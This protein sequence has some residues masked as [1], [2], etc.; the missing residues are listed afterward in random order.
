MT[1]A[2]AALHGCRVFVTGHTGFK[3]SWLTLWLSRLGATVTG[4]SL[5]AEPE[6]LFRLAGV[7]DAL[8]AH[9]EADIRDLAALSQALSAARPEIVFHLAAQPLVRASYADPLYTW[10]TNV[11]GTANLLE[12]V[13]AC[14]DVKA[15]VVVTTDKCYESRDTGPAYREGD[16]LGGHDPYSSS[17]A[18]A[19]LVAQSWRR[20][21]FQHGQSPLLATAR[22]GN[23]IGGGDFSV[24]RL[25]PDAARAVA[26]GRALEVRNPG[27][28]RPWQHVLESLRGYL[29]I[30]QGLA[31]GRTEFATAFNLGPSP[32]DNM[33]V[34]DVLQKLTVHWPELRWRTDAAAGKVLHEAPHLQLDSSKA[35]QMLD[36][37][38]AWNLDNAIEKTAYWYAQ[39]R[40]NPGQ[41]AQLTLRQISEFETAS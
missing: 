25:I 37:H 20:S 12:A 29:L 35:Q 18:A 39:A 5:A 15:V 26:H 33:A 31:Q 36:W 21:Y 38:P 41:A 2:V 19:E 4:Y 3:G 11:M 28:T 22:A 16:P 9:H 32:S 40:E 24:D 23:V 30:A 7:R 8:T 1:P 13:R 14:P 10:S 6:S 34:S 17:K 27:S